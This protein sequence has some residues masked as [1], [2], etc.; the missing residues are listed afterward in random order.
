MPRIGSASHAAAEAALN[1]R[2]S[3]LNSAHQAE[4]AEDKK[5]LLEQRTVVNRQKLVALQR[6]E[7]DL[8][9][10]QRTANASFQ[11]A[12]TVVSRER[13]ALSNLAKQ[14]EQLEAKKRNLRGAPGVAQ[15]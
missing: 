12:E 8:L 1:R 14:I 4:I 6:E 2:R 15:A 11:S 13:A 9:S 7:D 3:E 5:R 10:R